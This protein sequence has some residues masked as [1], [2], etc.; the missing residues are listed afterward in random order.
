[1][2]KKTTPSTAIPPSN[3]PIAWESIHER[4][5]RLRTMIDSGWRVEPER[6][7]A[8]LSTRAQQL[9]QPLVDNQAATKKLEIL[10]FSLALE[11]YAVVSDYVREVFPL[12]DF[13]PVPCTPAFVLGI[14]NVRGQIISIVDLRKFFGLPSGGITDL[15]KVIVLEDGDM[16]FGIV[17]D[18]I[19]EVRQITESELLPPANISGVSGQYLL[20][21]TAQRLSVIDTQKLLSD[22]TII[23]DEVVVA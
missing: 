17:V 21:V 3:T 12:N 1:M 4:L 15:N 13:T 6:V 22:K 9:A 8:I 10:E 14:A 5:D 19:V 2:T 7:D 11:H 20:G 23:V 16:S 18:F